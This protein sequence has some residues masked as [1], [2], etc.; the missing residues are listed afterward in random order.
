M[1]SATASMLVAQGLFGYFSAT[2]VFAL[3]RASADR[4]PARCLCSIA[5]RTG[6]RLPKADA[7]VEAIEPHHCFGQWI[8]ANSGRLLGFTQPSSK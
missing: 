1:T 3:I 7:K 6:Q 5:C 4:F 2:E 8:L